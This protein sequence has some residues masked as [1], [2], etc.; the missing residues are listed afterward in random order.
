MITIPFYRNGILQFSYK[1]LFKV[2]FK[3]RDFCHKKHDFPQKLKN[4]G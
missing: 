1:K 4:F 2:N 3:N